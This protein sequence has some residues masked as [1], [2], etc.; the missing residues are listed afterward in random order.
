MQRCAPVIYWLLARNKGW[1]LCRMSVPVWPFSVG[2]ASRGS[3][4]VTPLSHRTIPVLTDRMQTARGSIGRPILGE[5]LLPSITLRHLV[6]IEC[7]VLAHVLEAEHSK[8]APCTYHLAGYYSSSSATFPGPCCH[9]CGGNQTT[10]PFLILC[11]SA[12]DIFLSNCLPVRTI[13]FYQFRT[14]ELYAF[15]T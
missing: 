9:K 14:L 6:I 1:L 10:S 5:S 4:A 8:D 15:R 13:F 11:C 12:F 2:N 3:C 7:A